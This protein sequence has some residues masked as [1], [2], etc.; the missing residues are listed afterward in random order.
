MGAARHHDQPRALHQG[1]G[2]TAGEVEGAGRIRI[3][4]DDGQA[5]GDTGRH[6]LAREFDA[7]RIQVSQ[8]VQACEVC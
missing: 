2:G 8:A 4:L 6:A 3:A 7:A 5:L 1:R